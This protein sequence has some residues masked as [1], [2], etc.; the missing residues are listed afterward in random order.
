MNASLYWNH[1]LS[2]LPEFDRVTGRPEW[3]SAFAADARR[4]LAD[5]HR[6]GGWRGRSGTV[7]AVSVLLHCAAWLLW[8]SDA[9]APVVE[10]RIT[11]SVEVSLVAPAPAV[12]PAPQAQPQ[13]PPEVKP[14]PKPAL[15]HNTAAKRPL[16]RVEPEPQEAAASAPAPVS[17]PVPVAQAPAAPFVEAS[18]RASYLNNPPPKYPMLAKERQWEGLVVLKVQVLADGS[19]GGVSV[20]QSSGHDVLDAAAAEAAR[21]WRFVPA[22]RGEDNVASVVLVPIEFKLKS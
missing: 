2:S 11:R 3:Q 5:L 17:A 15:T 10:P 8:Q 13:T 21:R 14:K 6:K 9:I 16:P 18:Y 12:R 4:L 22:K 20:E 1:Q 7:I 19:S